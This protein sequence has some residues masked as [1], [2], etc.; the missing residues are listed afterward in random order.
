MSDNRTKG[1]ASQEPTSFKGGTKD[2]EN[3][4]YYYGKGMQQKC[5]TSSKKF[6]SYSGK[7]YGGS[8]KQSINHGVLKITEMTE[9]KRYK[10]QT[11][12]DAEDWSVKEDWKSDKNDYR[13][14]VRQV[15]ADL[16]R[17]YSI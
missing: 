8:V 15:K 13:K 14:I 10:T 4:I 1:Y 12:F 17:C 2:I 6:L 9:P 3:D 11:D 5:L 16:I 7:K